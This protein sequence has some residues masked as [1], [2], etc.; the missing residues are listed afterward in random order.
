M[1]EHNY[2]VVSEHGFAFSQRPRMYEH[3]DAT[4]VVYDVD[5]VGTDPALFAVD[6]HPED[7]WALTL[8]LRDSHVG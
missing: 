1:P 8:F 2:D 6:A 7:E 3:G 5:V 4:V